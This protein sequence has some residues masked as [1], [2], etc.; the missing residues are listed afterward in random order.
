MLAMPRPDR[1]KGRCLPASLVV[2]KRNPAL[3]GAGL[4]GIGL[5]FVIFPHGVETTNADSL[6][7]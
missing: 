4:F 6:R 3:C 7:E 5:R 1:Y 2:L